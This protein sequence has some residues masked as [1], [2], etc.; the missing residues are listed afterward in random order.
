MSFLGKWFGRA[1]KQ[2]PRVTFDAEC[3]TQFMPDG[4]T[5]TVRWNNLQEVGILTTDDGPMGDDV[6]WML[7]GTEGAGCAIPSET[8]GMQKLLTRLQQLEEFDN[9]AVIEAMGSTSNAKFVCWKR[10]R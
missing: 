9:D 10:L 1:S 6:F 5:E 4:K 8:E 7:L 2:K 3:I